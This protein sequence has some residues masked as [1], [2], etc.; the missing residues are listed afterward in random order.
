MRCPV[1]TLLHGT[2]RMLST[3]SAVVSST[4]FLHANGGAD[5]AYAPSLPGADRSGEG[6]IDKKE[7]QKEMDRRG[8][9]EKIDPVTGEMP[10]PCRW[11][12]CCDVTRP[13]SIS[14]EFAF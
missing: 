11:G 5:V 12:G 6:L 2:R 13:A 1:L 7:F 10:V 14:P 9:L 8:V 3:T 4:T